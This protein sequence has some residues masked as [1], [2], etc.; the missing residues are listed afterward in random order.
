MVYAVVADCRV[1]GRRE[2]II[3]RKGLMNLLLRVFRRTFRL[4][5][6]LMARLAQ[7]FKNSAHVS[8]SC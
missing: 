1:G 6:P 5:F 2:L 4:P 7:S 3:R 8:N